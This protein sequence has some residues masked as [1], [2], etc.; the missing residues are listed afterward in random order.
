MLTLAK[1]REDLK[2]I[3][4]YY[5]RKKIL[6]KI[7]GES[8]NAILDKVRFYNEAVRTAPVQL[9]DIYVS[10][11][12]NNS[13]QEALADDIGYSRE[14]ITALNKKLLLFLKKTLASK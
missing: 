13:T 6:D 14:H 1:I 4:Y 9:F 8:S 12:L 11:F 10:L 5:S 7:A 3:R 2:E